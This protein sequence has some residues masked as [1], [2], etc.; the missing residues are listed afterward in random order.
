VSLSED[1]SA[2]EPVSDGAFVGNDDRLD[3]DD[4]LRSLAPGERVCVSLCYGAGFSHTE[5]A[6]ALNAPLGTVKSHVKRGLDKLKARL[7]PAGKS[8]GL[9]ANG[10]G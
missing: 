2:L 5:A 8:L 6:A 10:H 4:A 9:E 3:L 1:V 7:A